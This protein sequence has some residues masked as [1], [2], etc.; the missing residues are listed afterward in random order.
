M[1]W[2]KIDLASYGH[3]VPHHTCSYVNLSCFYHSHSVTELI[4]S[5]PSI[6]AWTPYIVIARYFAA[7]NSSSEQWVTEKC[8]KQL[9]KLL[10][11]FI[12]QRLCKTYSYKCVCACVCTHT[13]IHLI[14]IQWR[15]QE[16]S[17]AACTSPPCNFKKYKRLQPQNVLQLL[18][19]IKMY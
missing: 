2:L 11:N 8:N 7:T 4:I 14:A 15:I 1:D 13:Y 18:M 6:K 3:V 10:I 19:M 5:V 9:R 16:A 12:S 17:E